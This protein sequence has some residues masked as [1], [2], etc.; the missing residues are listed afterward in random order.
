MIPFLPDPAVAPGALHSGAATTPLPASPSAP[1]QTGAGA[2]TLDFAGLLDAALPATV[3]ML[4]GATPG[5]EDITTSQG[6]S[7]APVDPLPQL[8]PPPLSIASALSGLRDAP[9][10]TAVADAPGGTILPERGADLPLP[11]PAAPFAGAQAQ[12]ETP[13]ILTEAQDDVAATGPERQ[14]P[15]AAD[16]TALAMPTAPI[17]APPPAA[18][19]AP[20]PTPVVV[21]A[22]GG[23]VPARPAPALSTAIPAALPAVAAAMRSP[24]RTVLTPAVMPL[25]PSDDAPMPAQAELQTPADGAAMPAAS[26]PA[27]ASPSPSPSAS[28]GASAAPAPLLAESAAGVAAANLSASQPANP[29]PTAVAPLAA[30]PANAPVMAE[31]AEPRSLA[32]DQESTIAAVGEI[33]EAL[34]AARPEMTLRHAEFGFVSLRLE[35]LVAGQQDWRA[36]LASRDPGF[37][38]AIQAALAE[39]MVPASSESAGAGANSGQSGMG[40]NGTSDQRYGSSPNGGQGSSSPYMGQSSGRDESG[41]A[42]RNGRQPSTT[43]AVA[44]RA[45]DGAAQ[46]DEPGQRGVFA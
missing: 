10:P 20:V 40:Q 27:S 32:P 28:P 43:D 17:P 33:R 26:G 30:A 15:Q 41:S 31:S 9:A 44:S 4:P 7:A 23:A 34:R 25:P 8:P 36:V 21:P 5:P 42:P 11:A 14:E 37:V 6:P 3:A 13:A 1:A 29:A 12:P 35:P 2:A 16:P 18:P 24:V 46:S 38:P 19:P 39:R 22:A 45:G